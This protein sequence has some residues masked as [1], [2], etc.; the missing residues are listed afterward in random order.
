MSAAN[1]PSRVGAALAYLPFLGWVYVILAQRHDALAVYHLKQSIGWFLFL[2]VVLVGW[3]VVA[4]LLAWI[5]YAFVCGVALF[6]LVIAALLYAVA[7][8][9]LGVRNALSARRV[10]LPVFGERANRLPIH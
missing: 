3:I 8:L 6:A 1:N 10:P 5:P 7:A 2:I 4:W 9:V